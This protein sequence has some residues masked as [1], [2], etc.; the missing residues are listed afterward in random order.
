MDDINYFSNWL[1]WGQF[2]LVM[3][4]PER[5]WYLPSLCATQNCPCMDWISNQASTAPK[6][7]SSSPFLRINPILPYASV[8]LHYSKEPISA[9][10]YYPDS[11]LF[12]DL[13]VHILT[14]LRLSSSSTL[15]IL[16][17]C[18]VGKMLHIFHNYLFYSFF[19]FLM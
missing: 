15:Q 6:K 9:G 3:V 13:A 19:N 1:I 4:Y 16:P 11:K 8:Y 12:T 5:S 14:W 10:L 2:F 18:R 17:Q 7:T